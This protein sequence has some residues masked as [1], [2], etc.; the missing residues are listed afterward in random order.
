MSNGPSFKLEVFD[1]EEGHSSVLEAFQEFVSQFAY[2]YDAM[3]REPPSSIKELREIAAWRAQ[4]RRK[5]FLG[6]FAHRNLQKLYEELSTPD[7]RDQMTFENMANLL[8]NR[9]KA[10]T[11]LSLANFNFRKL[12][13]EEKESF[14][15]F[16]IRV[17]REA[18]NCDFKCTAACCTVSDTMVRDQILFGTRDAEIRK[19]A[20]KEEWPLADLLTKGRAI[21]A[22]DIGAAT[23]KQEPLNEEI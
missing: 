10:N 9:F 16:T 2:S 1:P 4:Y 18:S 3:N 17:K 20:L 13:Q 11:N 19:N 23:I 15:A 12:K 6:R 8:T 14:E 21:E 22:S 5:V 7:T